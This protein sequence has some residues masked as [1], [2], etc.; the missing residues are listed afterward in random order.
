[1]SGGCWLTAFITKK[2][3]NNCTDGRTPTNILQKSM[4]IATRVPE[5][6]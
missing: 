4:K 2:R 6:G 3:Q 1:M 5:L